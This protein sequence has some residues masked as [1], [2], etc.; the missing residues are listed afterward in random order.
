RI[1]RIKMDYAART[2]HVC[3]NRS[4]RGV[5][6]V[7]SEFRLRTN[8]TFWYLCGRSNLVFG[9]G[10]TIL[11]DFAVARTVLASSPPRASAYPVHHR[12]SHPS[13]PVS[14]S[15]PWSASDLFSDAV[16]SRRTRIGHA[17]STCMAYTREGVAG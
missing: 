9:G 14:W 1:R 7:F 8:L 10:R 13:S 15:T 17:G 11:S 16:P 2:G 5:Y 12:R 3:N 4:D 6:F